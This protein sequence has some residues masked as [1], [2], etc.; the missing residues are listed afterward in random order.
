MSTVSLDIKKPDRAS[1]KVGDS[2]TSPSIAILGAVPPP[3]GGVSV[4][5]ARLIDRMQLRGLDYRLYDLNGRSDAARHIF[6][7]ARSVVWLI[8]FLLTCRETIVH[9][10]TE[11]VG[12]IIL[13][14]CI[15]PI[16]SRSLLVTL[17]G[18]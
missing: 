2:L 17:H 12:V 4:H 14:A 16:R 11:S 9:L 1:G 10:H 6:P 5:L 3:F 7:A 13:A 8:G 18:A 15:L